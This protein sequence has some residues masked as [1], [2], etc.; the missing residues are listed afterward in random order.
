M[1]GSSERITVGASCGAL[2]AV[3]WLMSRLK[4]TPVDLEYSL[5]YA[6]WFS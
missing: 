1:P 6:G 3:F 4:D 5:L 2:M